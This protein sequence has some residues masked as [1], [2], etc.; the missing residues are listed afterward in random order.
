MATY[1]AVP[2]PQNGSRTV[3]PH[4][5]KGLNYLA[6]ELQREHRVVGAEPGPPALGRA[7][8]GQS[9]HIP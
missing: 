8:T 6:S 7:K 3:S 4:L 5:L 1:G 2:R 9:R